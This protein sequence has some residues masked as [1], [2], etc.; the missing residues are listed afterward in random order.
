[1]PPTDRLTIWKR[2]ESGAEVIGGRHVAICRGGRRLSED[3][4]TVPGVL[5]KITLRALLVGVD[6]VDPLA[7]SSRHLS[8]EIDCIQQQNVGPC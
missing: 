4:Q 1:M 8:T 6:G 7:D 2:S 5:L 3:L